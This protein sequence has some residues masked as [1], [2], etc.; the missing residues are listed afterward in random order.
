MTPA[1]DAFVGRLDALGELGALARS[2]ALVTVTGPGGV[3]KTRL[4]LEWLGGRGETDA[5]RTA[6]VRLDG[7]SGE[8]AVLGAVAAAVDMPQTGGRPYREAIVGW[9]C[10]TELV[11]VLDNCEHVAE[12]AAALID[13]LLRD[14]KNLCV[15]ATSRTPLGYAGEVQLRLPMLDEAAALDLFLS[16]ASR[17]APELALQGGASDAAKAICRAMDGLPLAIELAAGWVGVLP[18]DEIAAQLTEGLDILQRRGPVP[19]RQANLTATMQWSHALLSPRARLLLRRLAAFPAGFA[20]GAVAPVCTGRE[21]ARGDVLPAL[22]ELVEHS[23]VQFDMGAARYRL[24]HTVRLFA[25]ALATQAG[26]FDEVKRA[27]AAHFSALA[28]E[29]RAADFVPED[30]WLPRLQAEVDNFHAALGTLLEAGCGAEA[31]QTAAALTLFW[32][33]ASRHREGIGWLRAALGQAD[34]APAALLAAAQ[35]GLGFLEAHDTGDWAAAARELDR[36]LAHLVGLNDP[37]ADHL[38]GYLL[39]LRGECDIMGG[40]AEAGLARA[41]EGA[42]LIARCPEDRWG[43]GFAAWNVGFGFERSGDWERAADR[44]RTVIATQR[45]G[46]LVVRMI[47]HQS[48]AHV[49]EHRG[50]ALDALPLY[51]EALAL[52]RR[53]GLSRL[54]DVHGSLA[55]LLADCARIR[56]AAGTGRD[57][58]KALA[59]EA[60]SVAERLRD[61]AAREAA[62][63][64]LRQLET[65]LHPVGLFR[66]QDGVWVVGLDGT[67]ALI[68]DSK[69]LRQL[70]HLLQSPEADIAA[71][72]LAAL[73]DGEP[74]E[75]G[76]GEPVLDREAI[77]A[78]RKRLAALERLL[79]ADE[80]ALSDEQRE[81]VR[82]EHESVS[83]ELSTSAGL[84]GRTRRLGSPDERMRVNVTRTLR[85]AIAEIEALCP[86]LGRHLAASV[87]TGS[88][89]RYRPASPIDWRF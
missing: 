12:D 78:Y 74:R 64:L 48:L 39:C 14:T 18:L 31:L 6:L 17:R 70:K 60:E 27:H 33:T 52:C 41:R 10:D 20:L 68:P 87:G 61:G 3:G 32:W 63:G 29:A 45:E 34:G 49:L 4:V 16:R 83:R 81:R 1:R 38:R 47:G 50:Q 37:G 22:R 73:A 86:A 62:A 76:R 80:D 24:L 85:A 23:L 75:T 53:V 36:G 5:R 79:A 51:D 13:A 72:D 66:R 25:M 84:G 58:S 44:Y 30:H 8:G 9:L 35:F 56:V 55:R 54:G 28:L 59:L 71:G 11:L 88:Y 21:L 67:Q 65:P 82:R 2:P 40:E 42:A 77:A 7:L 15:I 46:S 43:Q 26:E 89:C 69:G 19:A 57:E